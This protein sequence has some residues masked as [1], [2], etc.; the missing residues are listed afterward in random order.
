MKARPF[1]LQGGP[2]SLNV[3]RGPARAIARRVQSP[4]EISVVPSNEFSRRSPPPLVVIVDMGR[5]YVRNEYIWGGERVE[6][7]TTV[8][9]WP[10]LIFV[11]QDAQD[12]NERERIRKDIYVYMEREIERET[13]YGKQS[14]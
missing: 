1:H 10:T 13:R 8:S 3:A 9:R 2:A 14:N 5:I 7:T 11:R 12:W 6:E 4:L